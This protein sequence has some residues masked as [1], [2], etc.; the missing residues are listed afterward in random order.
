M[1][2]DN[3]FYTYRLKITINSLILYKAQRDVVGKVLKVLF[4]DS[5]LLHILV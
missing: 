1:L 2:L 4:M 3:V 5:F